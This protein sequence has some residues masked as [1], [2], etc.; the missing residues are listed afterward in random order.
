MSKK[1]Q[2]KFLPLLYLALGI[3]GFLLR[4]G[5]YATGV[6]E[7]GLLV[8]GHILEMILLALSVLSAALAVLLT[9]GGRVEEAERYV[10]SAG[11]AALIYGILYQVMMPDAGLAVLNRVYRIFG[12]AA[13]LSLI[14]QALFRVKK[15]SSFFPSYALLCIFLCLQ[16]VEGYQVWSKQ[17]QLEN[18]VFA[19]GS[20]LCMLLFTYHQAVRC[21]GQKP[22][23]LHIAYGLMGIFFGCVASAYGEFTIF[24]GAS[25]IWLLS[26]M[27][28]L[29]QE[30]GNAAA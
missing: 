1:S 28:C 17:P 25:A 2:C 27:S 13:M 6:D 18:Y 22:S 20:V 30:A 5:L 7:K 8:P 12:L 15:K 10:S 26:E 23:R 9:K 14:P 11:C 4:R 21:A 19:L 3:L 29:R 24:H 16:L